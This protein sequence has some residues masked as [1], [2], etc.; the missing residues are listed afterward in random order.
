ML[1]SD[2]GDIL[3]GGHSVQGIMP[4]SLII[5]FLLPKEIN[6]VLIIIIINY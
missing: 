3:T 2:T 6:R 5:A 4:V 1:L